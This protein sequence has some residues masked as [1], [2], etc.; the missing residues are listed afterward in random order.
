MAGK[1]MRLDPLTG[2]GYPTN[3]F[4]DGNPM[5][6]RSRVWTYGL[7]NPFRFTVRPGT[8]SSSPSAGSPGTVYMSDVGWADWEECNVIKQPG[9]NLGWPCYEGF[10]PNTDYQAAHPSHMGCDSVGISYWNPNPVSPPL[11][12]WNHSNPDASIPPGFRGNTATGGA[13]YTGNR[14]PVEFRNKYFFTDYGANWMKVMD[15]TNSDSLIDISPFA[16]DMEG[17]VDITT[18]PLN[19]DITYVSIF[20]FEVRR[21][22]YTGAGSGNQAP[23]A[24]A[25]GAPLSGVPP[26]TVNFSSAGSVD[27]DGDPVTT[28]WTF[29]DGFGST[30]PN[31]SHTYNSIGTYSAIL[32]LDDGHGGIGRDTVLVY[33]GTGVGFPT[34]GVLDDFNRANGP[35]GGS[36]TGLTTGLVIQDNMLTSSGGYATTVWNGAVFDTTQEAYFTL[37]QKTANCPEHDLMLKVQGTTSDAGHIEVRYNDNNKTVLVST[38]TPG[39][40][41]QTRGGPYSLTLNDGD[42][43]GARARRR[44]RGRVR[45]RPAVHHRQRRGMGVR[46]SRRA[47]RAHARQHRELEDRELRRRQLQHQ[48]RRSRAFPARWTRA[49]G[50]DTLSSSAARAT[51]S[52]GVGAPGHWSNRLIHNQL[53]TSSRSRRRQHAG[54]TSNHDDG[55]GVYLLLRYIVTDSGAK[56]DTAIVHCSRRTISS[57]PRSR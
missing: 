27:T 20:S 35:L 19:G 47:H 33:C 26:L 36:W 57:P 37:V 53:S 56:K 3:P 55:T 5:S 24:V 11:I 21:I 18:N 30:L 45:Q 28:V 14:Y 46:R 22:R 17:P 38:F 16:V 7:R 9:L 40:G 54:L 1:L 48:H 2:H 10:G 31:P 4:W 12:A 52:P 29:G 23:L 49:T 15:V 25:S 50:G 51:P 41:W 8:G 32:E 43:F 13:F 34:T 42:Q 44:P 39:P 6:V